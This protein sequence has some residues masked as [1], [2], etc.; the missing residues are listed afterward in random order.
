MN[1]CICTNVSMCIVNIYVYECINV[2]INLSRIEKVCL[3]RVEFV[4]LC[5]FFVTLLYCMIVCMHGFMSLMQEFQYV[6]V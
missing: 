3:W 2:C 6:V 1:E 5:V 4:Y